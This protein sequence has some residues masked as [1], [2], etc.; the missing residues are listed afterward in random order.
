MENNIESQNFGIKMEDL[1]I[2]R[3]KYENFLGNSVFF[4]N[5]NLQEKI[6]FLPESDRFLD[7]KLIRKLAV[8]QQKNNTNLIVKNLN[9]CF[10]YN[11]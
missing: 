4:L 1:N 6:F 7:V 8:S 10:K 5:E 2:L 11:F 3:K 9:I